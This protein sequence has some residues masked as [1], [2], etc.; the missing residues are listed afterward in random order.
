MLM[1]LG[2][3]THASLDRLLA[4]AAELSMML[5]APLPGRVAAAGPRW[6]LHAS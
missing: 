5:G 4:T 6:A 3:E 2:V 1:E